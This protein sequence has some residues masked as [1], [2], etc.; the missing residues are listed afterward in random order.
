MLGIFL[1]FAAGHLDSSI[2]QACARSNR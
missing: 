1:I 2:A